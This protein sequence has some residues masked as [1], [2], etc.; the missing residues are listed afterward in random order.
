[1]KKIS[2]VILSLI[3]TFTAI[4]KQNKHKKKQPQTG[5]IISVSMRRT[6]CF[7]RCPDYNIEINKDGIVTYTAIRFTPDTG[8]FTHSIGKSRAKE[9]LDQFTAYKV[10]TC[11]DL[12]ENRIPDL[13]GIKYE[14]KYADKTKKISC[15]NWGPY[16]LKELADSVD[17]AGRK[18]DNNG[19]KK[20]G[21]PKNQ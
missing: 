21:M 8:I 3:L 10:D 17:A 14:I 12:Y 19:W 6:T 1:M 18:T 13:P 2:L 16:F 20:T 11:K 15:A 9:I 5:G 4:S 7:G